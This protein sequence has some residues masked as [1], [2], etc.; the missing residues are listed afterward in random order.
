MDDV[1]VRA[2]I[3]A[4]DEGS[5]VLQEFGRTAGSTGS[6]V[7]AGLK[8]AAVG[9]AAAG[10][11][12][13]GFGALSVKAFMDHQNVQ[14]QIQSAIASTH[15]VSGLYLK[16]L[17]DQAIALQKVTKFSADQIGT[18]QALVLTF[19]NIKGAVAQQATP[20]ILDL[21]TAM[22]EDL[23]S[24]S[25][26]VGKALNDPVLGITALHR[27]GVTFSQTQKDQIKGFVDTNQMAKAQGIILK[28][29][30]TEFG[31]S[32]VAAG[33]TFSGSIAK[34]KNSLREMEITIGGTIS[35]SLEPFAAKA[36]TALAAVDWQKVVNNTIAVLK[37][38]G[39][40]IDSVYQKIKANLAP[41]VDNLKTAIENTWP[42]IKTF[43]DTYIIPLAK[44]V[45]T[46]AGEGLVG[47]INLAIQ[48]FTLLLLAAKPVMDWMNN[49]KGIVEG[50][51]GAFIALK[52][53]MLLQDA[54]AAL[55]IAFITFENIQ[56][57][58]M[59]ASLD[60][61]SAAF[62]E[63][64]PVA[65]VLAGLAIIVGEILKT[66]ALLDSLAD[67][68]AAERDADQNARDQMI[69]LTR[70]GSPAQKARATTALHNLHVPGYASGGIV[71]ATPGG[72]IIRVAEGGQDEAIIPL[73]S[74]RPLSSG[75]QTPSMI[76]ITV[77]AGAFMGSAQ[78]ARKYAQLILNAMQ[79]L[80]TSNGMSFDQ[81]WRHHGVRSI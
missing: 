70:T 37:D 33:S 20:A 21:S 6:L 2:L 68:E 53:A 15:D 56:V 36:A 57:P 44:T 3:T 67:Q 30:T 69:Q 50:V 13:A 16:D 32:A 45:G 10:V 8:A 60:A 18:V 17:N 28:E 5:A 72:Q 75:S 78:D 52:T 24:A 64:I 63:A 12:A 9:F 66:K 34:V 42:T 77:Q 46:V 22:H 40:N 41:V 79:D 48:T 65:A 81:L 26:Q 31:G 54:F 14:T 38:W 29:L 47:A 76:N 71:P 43:M 35:K 62:V 4:R 1:N 19:T 51:A 27:I 23:Q 11:A 61:L 59:I 25:V 49:N 80:A 39:K 7:T 55:Q 74:S 73:S 58:A